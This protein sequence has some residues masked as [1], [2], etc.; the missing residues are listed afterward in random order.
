[1]ADVLLFMWIIVYY[2]LCVWHAQTE[3]QDETRAYWD[4]ATN[5]ARRPEC[6]AIVNR[7]LDTMQRELVPLTLSCN[8]DARK[9]YGMV[10]IECMDALGRMS[11][12][13][14]SASFEH[15]SM[16]Y[17]RCVMHQ[18]AMDELGVDCEYSSFYCRF[19]A[20]RLLAN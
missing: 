10:V 7:Y 3:L 16:D 14:F 5:A 18:S 17:M 20:R 1:M 6:R 13:E 12:T 11:P 19:I 15:N 8:N 9:E 4:N 2:G